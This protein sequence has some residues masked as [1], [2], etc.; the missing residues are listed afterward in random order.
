MIR[1]G[2]RGS[3]RESTWIGNRFVIAAMSDFILRE[4]FL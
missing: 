3:V 2:I 4:K 1:A